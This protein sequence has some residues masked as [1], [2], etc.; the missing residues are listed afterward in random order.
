V[1]YSDLGQYETAIKP[2][3][4]AII[5]SEDYFAP[6][7]VL[8]FC[9]LELGRYDEAIKI[10][11][12]ALKIKPYN[13]EALSSIGVAY[14]RT[15]RYPEAIRQFERAIKADPSFV[16]GY[17]NLGTTYDQMGESEKAIQIYEQAAA[18]TRSVQSIAIAY[19]R[20]GDVC[21]K[22]KDP[23]KA[24]AYYNK[25]LTLCGSGMVELKKLVADRL[26]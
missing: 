15:K 3:V 10:L 8:G 4:K 24:K 12:D 2:L 11:T 16:D 5:L 19:V 17:M 23:E 21:R 20:I 25:A 22:L 18:S 14:A 7:N 1:A 6:R 26:K 9:Y 13:L